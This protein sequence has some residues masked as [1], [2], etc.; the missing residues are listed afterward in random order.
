MLTSQFKFLL[1]PVSQIYSADV[2]IPLNPGFK[3]VPVVIDSALGN[4]TVITVAWSYSTTI[5]VVVTG[6]DGK[7][8]DQNDTEYN[9]DPT[10]RIISIRLPK[11]LVSTYPCCDDILIPLDSLSQIQG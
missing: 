8:V 2:D 4:D 5:S 6:P 10:S 7:T 1:F 11:A 3:V 9:I